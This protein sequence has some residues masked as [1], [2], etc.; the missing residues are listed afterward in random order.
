[1]VIL[2][3]DMTKLYLSTSLEKPGAIKLTNDGINIS[4]IIVII[5]IKYMSKEKIFLGKNSTSLFLSS[6]SLL[7]ANVEEKIGI[8]AELKAPS[9]K[10]FLKKFGNLKAV[11][12]TSAK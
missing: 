9:V 10:I 3:R 5:N 12:K 8:K 2:D 6:F 1:M 4:A 11:K 7:F